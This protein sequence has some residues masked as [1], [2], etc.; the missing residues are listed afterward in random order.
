MAIQYIDP[1]SRGWGRMK[2]ALFKP[3][4]FKK[5]LLVGFTAFLAQ[6]ADFGGGGGGTPMMLLRIHL[7]RITGEVRVA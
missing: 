2:R 4:D 1:L 6:L 3:F 5:W 7:P